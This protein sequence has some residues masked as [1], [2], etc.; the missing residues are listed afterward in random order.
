MDP[1]YLSSTV[2]SGSIDYDLA[3]STGIRLCIRH[4]VHASI[5][6]PGFLRFAP[7]PQRCSVDT[8]R[9]VLRQLCLHFLHSVDRR[10]F[11]HYWCQDP[12]PI[13]TPSQALWTL[14]PCMLSVGSLHPHED[15]FVILRAKTSSTV[16][17]PHRHSSWRHRCHHDQSADPSDHQHVNLQLARSVFFTLG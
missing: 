5:H 4:P 17:P 14:L 11:D 7:N 8:P 12:L 13:R 2:R 6:V 1:Q 9:S 15:T 16:L 10:G 3:W